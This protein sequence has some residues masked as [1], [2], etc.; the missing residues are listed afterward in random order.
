MTW[1][2]CVCA[3]LLSC[4][5]MT[6]DLYAEPVCVMGGSGE[7]SVYTKH[8]YLFR[9]IEDAHLTFCKRLDLS[10]GLPSYDEHQTRCECH[11]VDVRTMEGIFIV[12]YIVLTCLN[13]YVSVML[14]QLLHGLV[15]F[16]EFY[17]V[18]RWLVFV[19]NKNVGI[20]V[21]NKLAN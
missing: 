9:E 16:Y 19:K 5:L 12:F 18:C 2:L 7:R 1:V 10:S 17:F 20:I 13:S 14:S 6:Y 4:S 15:C 8:V 3:I 21:Q 11:I